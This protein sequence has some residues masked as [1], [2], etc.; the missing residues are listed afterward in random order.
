MPKFGR[1]TGK[2]SLQDNKYIRNN[3]TYLG[4]M[5]GQITSSL[6]QMQIDFS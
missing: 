3:Y 6:A 5:H 2:T 1:N 4:F